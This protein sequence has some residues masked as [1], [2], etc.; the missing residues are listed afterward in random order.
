M[1]FGEIVKT[2][3]TKKGLTLD[4]L[5]QKIGVSNASISRWETGEI[6]N[7]RS[8]KIGPLADALGTSTEYL[9][10]RTPDPAPSQNRGPVPIYLHDECILST[11][12]P[13]IAIAERM[14]ERAAE[15]LV[16][17]VE[18]ICCDSSFVRSP[19]NAQIPILDEECVDVTVDFIKR[20]S[21]LLKAQ[22]KA[23]KTK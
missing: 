20:N 16:T 22:T 5:A 8:D 3:R 18:E 15:K 2:L 9:L 6:K 14:R 13:D 12:A 7:I 17:T 4:E 19:S 1:E 10:G 21:D 11:E 23:R